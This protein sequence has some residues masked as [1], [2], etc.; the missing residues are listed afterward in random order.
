[1]KATLEGF[2]SVRN[3]VFR[4]KMVTVGQWTCVLGPHS[5]RALRILSRIG[6]GP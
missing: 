4:L 1:M 6:G 2:R 3:A 5:I